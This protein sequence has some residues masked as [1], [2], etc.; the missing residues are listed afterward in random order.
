M[1]VTDN[2]FRLILVLVLIVYVNLFVDG[3]VSSTSQDYKQALKNSLLYFEAQRSGVLPP[4]QRVDLVGGYYDAGDNVKFGFPMAYTITQLAW[5]VVE[6]KA[7][8]EAQNELQN[9]LSAI[10]WGADYL[11][12][13]HP[14][15]NVLYA[16]VGDGDSDHQ[17]W[18]RPEDMTTP[19][20]VHKIDKQSPGSDLAG[21]TAAAMAAASLAFKDVDPKYSLL[22]LSHAR[23]V[24][25]F[26]TSHEGRYTDSIPSAAQFYSSSGFKDELLW[27]AAWLE[28]AT[29]EK[30]YM[31]LLQN[32]QD[33]GGVRT[34]FS[35][36]DKYVGAQILVAKL[37]LEGK[38]PNSGNLGG[39]KQQAEEFLCNCIQK[40]NNNVFKTSGGL[41]WFNQWNNLQYTTSASMALAVYADYLSAS[42]QALKCASSLANPSDLI[43]FARSQVDYILGANPRNSSYM[44]GFGSNYPQ[45]AH[46]RGASIVSIKKDPTPVGCKDGFDRWFNNAQPNPNV[47]VGA[48]VGGPDRSDNYAD[49]RSNYQLAEPATANTAPLVG[50]LARISST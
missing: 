35:W 30:P 19:R 32:T 6:F 12:K 25:D 38:L 37:I 47:L 29:G 20:T 5:A 50:V 2:R 40:G 28:R 42:G 18:E 3:V 14:E 22:L 41:L 7:Q 33:T 46:H 44:V 11:I 24:F 15:P 34:M 43:A 31:D 23:E 45:Q 17:C 8:L 9:A 21:E 26:A 39:F 48:I 49:Q 36:D 16:G 10:K 4:N 13:A 27:A 1:S